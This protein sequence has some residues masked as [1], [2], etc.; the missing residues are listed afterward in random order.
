MGAIEAPRSWPELL[1]EA[2]LGDVR[3]RTFLLDL[4]APLDGAARRHLHRHLRVAREM[5]ADGLTEDDLA[6]LDRLAADGGPESVLERAD[7]F[8]LRASTV[9]TGVNGKR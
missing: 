9:H 1:R 7:V 5:L 2:G 8:L 6:T 4:P 3:S